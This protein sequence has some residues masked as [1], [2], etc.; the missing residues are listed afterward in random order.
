MTSDAKE[1]LVQNLGVAED[2]LAA[3]TVCGAA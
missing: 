2:E 1:V 3:S